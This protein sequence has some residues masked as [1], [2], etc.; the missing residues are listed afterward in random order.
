MKM[1]MV[2]VMDGL[3]W[4]MD[5]KWVENLN[6]AGKQFLKSSKLSTKKSVLFVLV[7]IWLPNNKTVS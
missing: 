5:Y 4:E 6:D 7:S 1:I 2:I 3:N